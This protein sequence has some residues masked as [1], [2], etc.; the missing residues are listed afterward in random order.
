MYT[1]DSPS[2]INISGA[3]LSHGNCAAESTPQFFSSESPVFLL[4]SS[5]IWFIISISV[6]YLEITLTF[7]GNLLVLIAIS[8]FTYLRAHV[9][10]FICGLSL[11][12]LVSISL[13]PFIHFQL[14]Y[15]NTMAA[16][17]VCHAQ[18]MLMFLF[19]LGNLLFSLLIA[20]E[21]L[22]T[23]SYPLSHSTIITDSR[24]T[25]VFI[26]SW[27]YLFLFTAVLPITSHHRI[28]T[29]ESLVCQASFVMPTLTHSVLTAQV[30]IINLGKIKVP[31][32]NL[33]HVHNTK[34]CYHV[35]KISRRVYL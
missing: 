3:T 28:M 20:L 2:S 10:W 4:T 33:S 5:D 29:L 27:I 23:L 11:S 12:D 1:S 24:V 35:I 26:F 18:L 7:A 14:H 30:Y 8:R 22:I 13:T 31:H 34:V 32:V 9:Y 6:R 15:V 16:R 19:G 25:K 21:R 17:Y